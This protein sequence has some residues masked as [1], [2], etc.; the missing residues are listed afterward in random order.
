MIFRTKDLQYIFQPAD[1]S[2][3]HK[4]NKKIFE[5]Y[6]KEFKKEN[7]INQNYPAISSFFLEQAISDF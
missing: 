3:P 4:S 7:I 5:V 6:N 1:Q 2:Y